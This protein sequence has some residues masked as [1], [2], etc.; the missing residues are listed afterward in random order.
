M[1][2]PWSRS[3]RAKKPPGQALGADV[4]VRNYDG[5]EVMVKAEQ[6]DGEGWFHATISGATLPFACVLTAFLR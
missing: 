4:P 5:R 3:V 6:A 2:E 1:V